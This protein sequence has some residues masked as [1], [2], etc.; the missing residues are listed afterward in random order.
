MCRRDAQTC[1]G[2]EQ[3]KTQAMKAGVAEGK[4]AAMDGWMVMLLGREQVC[5]VDVTSAVRQWYET[6]KEWKWSSCE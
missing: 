4:V 5:L 1:R 2:T 6:V 3:A